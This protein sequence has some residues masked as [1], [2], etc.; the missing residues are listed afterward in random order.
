MWPGNFVKKCTFHSV[1]DHKVLK[2][3]RFTD[4]VWTF[5]NIGSN[6]VYLHASWMSYR[7]F[8]EWTTENCSIHTITNEYKYPAH[9]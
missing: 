2:A 8:T 9:N 7:C 5:Y 3:C 4:P 1:C 6:V